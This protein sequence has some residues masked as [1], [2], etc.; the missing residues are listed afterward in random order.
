MTV[1]GAKTAESMVVGCGRRDRGEGRRDGERDDRD[2][3][4]GRDRPRARGCGSASCS[5]LP[6]HGRCTAMANGQTPPGVGE[7]GAR[8][9]VVERGQQRSTVGRPRSRETLPE[10]AI[11]GCE[12]LSMKSVAAVDPI[13]DRRSGDVAATCRT[14]RDVAPSPAA[15]SAS[16]RSRYGRA[17][18]RAQDRP[19]IGQ[20]AFGRMARRS[21]ARGP[22]RAR[23]SPAR[24]RARVPPAG[25]GPPGTPPA[26]RPVAVDGRDRGADDLALEPHERSGQGGILEACPHRPQAVDV[27][28]PQHR[29]ARPGPRPSTRS[30]CSMSDDSSQPSAASR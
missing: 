22:C 17:P 21:R 24:T 7:G 27:V 20:R 11:L 28:R 5:S 8:T 13:S 15:S 26:R 1:T 25:A 30:R 9:R 3:D 19:R 18:S 23:P 6:G 10:A 14:S 2:D 12:V 4:A 16:S 29:P